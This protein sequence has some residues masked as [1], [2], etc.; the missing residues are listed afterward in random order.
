MMSSTEPRRVRNRDLFAE[1]RFALGRFPTGVAF[2]ATRASNGDA[3]GLLINS[4]TSASL[5][6]PLVA[7]YL[8][9]GSRSC[10]IFSRAATFAVSI[11]SADQKFLLN[12]LG[13]PLEARLQGIPVRNGLGGAPVLH[14]AAA[15][16]ECRTHSISL[17]GDHNLFLG[18]VEKFDTN[19]QDPLAYLNGKF[20]CVQIPA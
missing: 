5:D 9:L 6:P 11:L 15:S 13:R 3:A 12:S 1:Y 19:G 18:F 2:V 8:A 16:F 4:F 17:A 7:W 14:G 20:G 10:P